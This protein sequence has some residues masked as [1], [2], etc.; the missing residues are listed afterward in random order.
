MIPIEEI[1]VWNDRTLLRWLNRVHE[2]FGYVT[3]LGLPDLKDRGDLPISRLFV[4]PTLQKTPKVG[5]GP[6]II[7]V[8][9]QHDVVVVLGDPGSGKSTL[10]SWVTHS[11]S[12]RARNFATDT[13]GRRI[14]LPF[15]LRDLQIDGDTD[16]FPKL[17]RRL[18]NQP[19][20]TLKDDPILE[21]A[22]QAGQAVVMIDG[23]DEISSK[24]ARE[25]LRRAIGHGI[26]RYPN[27]KWLMTS[28]ILGW[29]QWAEEARSGLL[30]ALE[31]SRAPMEGIV[32]RRGSFLDSSHDTLSRALRAVKL[33]DFSVPSPSETDVVSPNVGQIQLSLWSSALIEALTS[34]DPSTS[35]HPSWRGLLRE[36]AHNQRGDAVFSFQPE[37]YYVQ[38]FDESRIR[39]FAHN[40]YRLRVGDHGDADQRA[41]SL[42]AAV[43]ET[44]ALRE[45]A[46]TPNLLALMALV[47]RV[48]TRLPAGR[49]VLYDKIAEAYL[50]SIDRAYG[51]EAL[52][53]PLDDK[54]RWI[55]SIALEMQ[56]RRVR[57][58]TDNSARSDA[59]ILLSRSD[60]ARLLQELGAPAEEFLRWA[61]QRAGLLVPRTEDSVA[62]THLS[63][64]EHL[65]ARHIQSQLVSGSFRPRER[66]RLLKELQDWLYLPSCR[67]VLVQLFEGLRSFPG[68]GADVLHRLVRGWED[69]T[70]QEWEALGALIAELLSDEGT[71]L[72]GCAPVIRTMT[73]L[74][75]AF[76][77]AEQRIPAW[78]PDTTVLA[79]LQLRG[80]LRLDAPE[81]ITDWKPSWAPNADRTVIVSVGSSWPRTLANILDGEGVA[82]L[83]VVGD[84]QDLE[85]LR[86]VRLPP[87]LHLELGELSDLSVLE[88]H[89]QLHDLQLER[90]G[91][92]TDFRPLRRIRSLRVGDYPCTDLRALAPLQ[93][94]ERLVIQSKALSSTDGIEALH[95]LVELRLSG[96]H[97]LV[98][99]EGL[100]VLPRLRTLSVDDCPNVSRMSP[101]PA[102][103]EF[104]T[105]S[106]VE[107]GLIERGV[108][109]GPLPP[110]LDVGG[111][112]GVTQLSMGSGVREVTIKNCPSLRSVEWMFP[113]TLTSIKLTGL[114]VLASVSGMGVAVNGRVEILG[115][116]LTHLPRL[117]KRLQTLVL[118]GNESLHFEDV[119]GETTVVDSL[120]LNWN[121]WRAGSSPPAVRSLTAANLSGWPE[122]RLNRWVGEEVAQLVLEDCGSVTGWPSLANNKRL[123]GLF[124]IRTAFTGVPSLAGCENL[125]D[126]AFF[127][128]P[129]EFNLQA[130]SAHPAL[131]SLYLYECDGLHD[132]E[133]L[134]TARQLRHVS[135]SE[136]RGVSDLS[137]LSRLP[138]GGVVGVHGTSVRR[139]PKGLKWHVYGLRRRR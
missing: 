127:Q 78:V 9:A 121:G 26:S 66:E 18:R 108:L 46:G 50:E 47:H 139:V 129:G 93:A 85:G 32:T 74:V 104:L 64:Q 13:L 8:L 117:P 125:R 52:N 133:P 23:L 124:L 83:H 48:H 134:G 11:L 37:V 65:A 86:G 1:D 5:G 60:A 99:V 55:S 97:A 7:E 88:E 59:E 28:R 132:I 16:T 112:Q 87:R 24:P 75:R 56:R 119:G 130:F 10:V 40:W 42:L 94:V 73:Q 72:L 4:A 45:L 12:A 136:C 81:S 17:L 102:Q 25:A 135:L 91:A 53:V 89:H 105:L 20:S 49:A 22:L 92:V 3:M 44:P 122:V 115:T 2:R 126:C 15:L 98:G 77:E 82:E 114:P 111:L 128:V 38:P 120:A 61:A 58:T 33:Q 113:T 100:S 21:A 138:E 35:S 19:W 110:K 6:D 137:P 31:D 79:G 39:A 71:G 123:V 103:L 14:P 101:L 43:T 107:D 68:L 27:V 96:C 51:I 34:P 80:P 84:V 76:V 67:E 54:L 63:F 106:G 57:A 69:R 70:T 30:Y 90:A 116:G 62:F 95:S 131:T 118:G 36:L 29:N 109:S 41:R